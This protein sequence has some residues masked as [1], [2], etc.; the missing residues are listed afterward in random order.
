MLFEFA[1]AQGP[2]LRGPPSTGPEPWNIVRA[3]SV[4]GKGEPG[5]REREAEVELFQLVP[6]TNMNRELK[7]GDR[8]V[9]PDIDALR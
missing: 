4:N 2:A 3:R 7:E 1:V 6:V 8:V 5:E 9:R